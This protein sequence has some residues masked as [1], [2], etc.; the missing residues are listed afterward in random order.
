M[1]I[2]KK[3]FSKGTFLL[4]SVFIKVSAKKKDRTNVFFGLFQIIYSALL[5]EFGENTGILFLIVSHKN[6]G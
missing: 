4:A 3:D 6:A 1:F 2:P 5:T